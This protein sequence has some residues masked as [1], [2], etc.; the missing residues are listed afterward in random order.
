[1]EMSLCVGSIDSV[2]EIRVLKYKGDIIE[3][4]TGVL[5]YYYADN[6][7]I[8]D[9]IALG[10]PFLARLPAIYTKNWTVGHLRREIPVGYRESMQTGENHIV[11]PDL[12]EYLDILWDITRSYSIFDKDRIEKIKN[13]RSKLRGI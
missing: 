8:N 2:N 5:M 12:H 9:T 1:M 11:D 4:T 13:P 10:Y 6:I 7:Y 3:W